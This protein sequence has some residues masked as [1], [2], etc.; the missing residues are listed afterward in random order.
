MKDLQLSQRR[1]QVLRVV[2]QEYVKSAQPVGSKSIAQKY[3]MGVSASTIRNDL[4]AL[5]KAGLL[6]H[7]HTSAGRIPTDKVTA[8]S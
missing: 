3:D 5:E 6:T 1:K 8:I 4:A 7:P 2:I